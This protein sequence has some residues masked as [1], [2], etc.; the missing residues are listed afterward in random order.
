MHIPFKPQ[1]KKKNT[2]INTP[3]L[4]AINN[5][6]HNTITYNNQSKHSKQYTP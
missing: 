5:N 1:K 6:I 3:T 4:K 2:I